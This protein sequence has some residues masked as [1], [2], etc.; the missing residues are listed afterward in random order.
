M[1]MNYY[2]VSC[3]GFLISETAAAYIIA[4]AAQK[5]ARKNGE[6]HQDYPK[7]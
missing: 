1:S 5:E 2:A 6:N 7:K 3:H 4:A